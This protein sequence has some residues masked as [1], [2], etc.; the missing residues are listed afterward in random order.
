MLEW[1]AVVLHAPLAQ[2]DLVATVDSGEVLG[3]SSRS[4][5][6]PETSILSPKLR[7]ISQVFLRSTLRVCPLHICRRVV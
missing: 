5:R 1:F 6:S 2:T 4:T 3:A 7:Y